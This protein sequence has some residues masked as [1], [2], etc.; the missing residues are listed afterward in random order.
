[1]ENIYEQTVEIKTDH[2]DCENYYSLI[3][4]M[5]HIQDV[6]NEHTFSLGVDFDNM[7]QKSNAFWVILKMKLKIFKYPR[8]TDKV[9]VKTYPLP[10]SLVRCDRESVITDGSGGIVAVSSGEW[11]ILDM[12][13]KRPRKISTC[14]YPVELVHDM[15]RVLPERA[16]RLVCDFSESDLCY[17]K[18]VRYSDLDLNYHTN[19]ISYTKFALDS[20]SAEFFR[21]KVIS[22]YDINFENQS[23]EGDVIGIYRK[24]TSPG[25]YMLAGIL[26][27]DGK[28]IFT[29]K[30]SL[31]ERN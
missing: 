13:T 2:V 21:N 5:S 1:M 25:T 22:E 7:T 29:V 23:Y 10:P 9:K 28:R 14:C 17:E 20:F 3:G 12:D 31:I 8:W 26:K 11:C 30:M 27:A 16:E 24:E 19:N 6:V 4:I 15:P 18:T